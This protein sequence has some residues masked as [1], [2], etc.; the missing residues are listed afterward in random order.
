MFGSYPTN[1]IGIRHL[2]FKFACNYFM[3]KINYFWVF[4]IDHSYKTPQYFVLNK[5]FLIRVQISKLFKGKV[6]YF[7]T[8]PYLRRIM[9]YLFNI[10]VKWSVSNNF[11]FLPLSA[12]TFLYIIL[13]T[14]IETIFRRLFQIWMLFSL[15]A[16][17]N[18][19]KCEPGVKIN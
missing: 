16:E 17:D 7:Y 10:I 13:T 14:W 6:I 9:F 11:F 19:I 2:R 18:M 5:I 1:F 12:K 3:W 8:W 15:K 4:N